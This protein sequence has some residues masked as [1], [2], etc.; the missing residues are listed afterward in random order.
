MK[1]IGILQ[2]RNNDKRVCMLPETVKK[3][4][5]NGI[6]V[7]FES[8]VGTGLGILNVEYQKAGAVCTTSDKIYEE[9]NLICSIN[10]RYNNEK[11]SSEA[12]FLGVFNPLFHKDELKRYAQWTSVYSLDLLPRSTIAQTMD[13]QSSMASLAGYK[14]VILAANYLNSSLPMFTTAAGTIKPAK[15]LVLGAG[16]AGLQAIATI[17]RMG[18]IVEAFDVRSSAAEEVR[19]L[20]ARFIEVE[21]AKESSAA[22]GY[23]IVQSDDFLQ[24]QQQLIHES[25]TK[26]DIVICT[27]N[28]PG[29]EA[30]ILLKQNTIEQMK[31][32][33]VIVDL[34]SEQGG[35][36]ELSK[37]NEIVQHDGV[38]IIGNSHLSKTIPFAASQLLSNNYYNYINLFLKD[39]QHELIKAT[40]LI[41]KGAIIHPRLQEQNTHNLI[42]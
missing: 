11:L 37:N 10:H 25:A 12:I 4:T 2:E 23:A 19:S 30:P 18:A 35:N 3:L 5:H 41:E 9:A 1:T 34:A 40:Q 28:I 33:S 15:V 6:N 29:K 8:Q 22:G 16:V 38:T 7:L 39:P 20:G 17:K 27:A 14:A 31:K 36:C 21:G 32:G 24:R 42:Q 26:A 13:V